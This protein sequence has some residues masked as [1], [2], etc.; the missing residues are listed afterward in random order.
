MSVTIPGPG[1]PGRGERGERAGEHG[2]D[3]GRDEEQPAA[4]HAVGERAAD[5]AEHRAR[6]EPG[7]GDEPGPHRLARRLGDE[8]AD[9]D[10]LHPRADVRDER[11]GP[12]DREHAVPERRERT[13]HV[14]GNLPVAVEPSTAGIGRNLA[15]WTAR[16]DRTGRSSRPRTSAPGWRPTRRSRC[17]R[18]TGSRRRASTATPAGGCPTSSL[19]DGFRVVVFDEDLDAAKALLAAE[20]DVRGRARVGLRSAPD[21]APSAERQVQMLAGALQRLG[22]DLGLA[23]D[24]PVAHEHLPVDDDG[25]DGR[26]ARRVDERLEQRTAASSRRRSRR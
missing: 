8:D 6:H 19:L 5:R 1:L 12:Q 22:A 16:H 18:P 3:R 13:V 25:V 2:L 14:A 11:A 10:G 4:R 9:A 20:H 26:A 23:V 17:S 24:L 7:G 21:R 15:R